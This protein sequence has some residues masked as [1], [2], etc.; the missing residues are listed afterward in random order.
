MTRWWGKLV[1]RRRG[2]RG[3]LASKL[4]KVRQLLGRF[5]NRLYNLLQK[6]RGVT[7]LMFVYIIFIF[8]A[9]ALVWTLLPLLLLLAPLPFPPTVKLMKG[10]ASSYINKLLN[11]WLAD[12]QTTREL[13]LLKRT[14]QSLKG[15]LSVIF[16]STAARTIDKRLQRCRNQRTSEELATAREA[17]RYK[18]PISNPGRDYPYNAGIE[19]SSDT[20]RYFLVHCFLTTTLSIYRDI[21]EACSLGLPSL[22]ALGVPRLIPSGRGSGGWMSGPTAS[23]RRLF[24]SSRVPSVEEGALRDS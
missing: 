12:Q 5:N 8:I 21:G 1:K 7:L 24:N 17:L 23:R 2:H 10:K 18:D 22:V 19:L 20:F 9:L 13:N 4:D 11:L 15:D 14:S 16:V 6:H 3:P